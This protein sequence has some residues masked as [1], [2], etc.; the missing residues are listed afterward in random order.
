MDKTVRR[1]FVEKKEAFR[2]DSA[3][4]LADLKENLQLNSLT[5]VRLIN[6]YNVEGLDE[7]EYALAKRLVFSEAPVDDCFDEEMSY[8]VG[9]KVFAVEFLPGQFD[10]R[11]DSAEECISIITQ[12]ERPKV[13]YAKV[14]VLEGNVSETEL[15]A[16]KSY[17]VNPVEARIASLEKPT[18]LEDKVPAPSDVAEVENFIS[19]DKDA[20]ASFASRMG[21]AMDMD[22]LAFCQTYFAQTEKRNPT[23]TEMRMIDTY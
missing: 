11:A 20:L 5:N 15:E 4:L 9:S 16:I 17:V 19:M 12:K 7:N 22:D 23:I 2:L 21:F 14:Y 1:I 10:Q 8:P 18:T 3:A 13:R 6:R